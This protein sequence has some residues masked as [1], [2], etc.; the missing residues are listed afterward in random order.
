MLR[1]K[2]YLPY[3]AEPAPSA[4]PDEGIPIPL[5]EIMASSS[6]SGLGNDRTRKRSLGEDGDARP[7]KGARLSADGDF[8]RYGNG[9]QWAGQQGMG[10]FGMGMQNGRQQAY[11]PPGQ[12][13]RGICRDYHSTYC[14][15]SLF[16]PILTFKRSRILRSGRNLQVQSRRRC[17][18]SV[19]TVPYGPSANDA[20][21]LQHVRTRW[22]TVRP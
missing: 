6:S 13:K 1:T 3:A 10:G 15:H 2:S 19:T 21:L 8:S 9:G 18:Y 11:R 4:L 22:R 14:V 20:L 12:A 5:D 17:C 7:T 16:S